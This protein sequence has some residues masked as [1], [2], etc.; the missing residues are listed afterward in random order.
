AVRKGETALADKFSAAIKAI[1]ANGKYK[2]IND[3]HFDFDV[4]G[5]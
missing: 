3:K 4:Y 5:E 2:E 1:R